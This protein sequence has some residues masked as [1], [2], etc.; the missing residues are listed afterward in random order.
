MPLNFYFL[1][2]WSYLSLREVIQ[3]SKRKHKNQWLKMVDLLNVDSIHQ[4]NL[5]WMSSQVKIVHHGMLKNRIGIKNCS[6]IFPIVPFFILFII[7]FISEEKGDEKKVKSK[8]RLAHAQFSST[9]T[10]DLLLS[11]KYLQIQ[12]RNSSCKVYSLILNNCGMC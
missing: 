1:H 5:L 12:C 3:Y 4:K 11:S 10:R 2:P 8:C 6:L 7:F 9:W